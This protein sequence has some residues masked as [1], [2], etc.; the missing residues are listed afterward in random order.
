ME[1]ESDFK[2]KCRARSEEQTSRCY[3]DISN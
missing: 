3:Y 1:S 2:N